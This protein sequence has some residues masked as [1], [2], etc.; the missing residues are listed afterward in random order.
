MVGPDHPALLPGSRGAGGHLSRL[1]LG[2]S[3]WLKPAV[4]AVT[5]YQG[6][7]DA[8][9]PCFSLHDTPSRPSGTRCP[10]AAAAARTSPGGA[11][12]A[13][14]RGNHPPAAARAG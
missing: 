13:S 3:G 6:D 5:A 7:Q 2:V 12:T 8:A 4:E 1:G 10:P 14:C 11:T 9:R